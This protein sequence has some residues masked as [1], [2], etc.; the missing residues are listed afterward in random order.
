MI[1]VAPDHVESFTGRLTKKVTAADQN[2]ISGKYFYEPGTIIYSKIRPYL[3][4]A[5]LVDFRG[6]CSADM[7][8]LTPLPNISAGYVIAHLLSNRFTKFVESVSARSGI[9]KVNRQDLAE[10][11]IPVPPFPEQQ[12]IAEVLSDMDALI[13]AQEALIEK[14]RAIKQGAMQELLTGRR[15]LPGFEGEWLEKRFADVMTGFSSGATPYRGNPEFFD[16]DINWITSGELKYSTIFTTNERITEQAV[17]KTNLSILPAGTFLIAITGLEA[18]GTRGSCGIVGT[19][20]TSNQSCMAL[21]PG[22]DLELAYLFHYYCL[23]GEKLALEY[24]QGT[25]QQSYTGSIVKTL[26]IRLPPSLEEQRAIALLLDD[27]DRELHSLEENLSK[28]RTLKQGMMQELL[29]GRVRLV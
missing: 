27:I 25:K 5:V 23:N 6:L 20:S 7:Y 17:R 9:P 22:I 3:V 16:G 15:R 10:F 13:A 2:A 14:K 24:C 26:P 18:A 21:Y 1:M 8:P 4:K 29:T 11:K 19:P 12:A 28:Q